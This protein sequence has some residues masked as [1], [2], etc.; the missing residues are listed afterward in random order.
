MKGAT[1]SQRDIE[2]TKLQ[3]SLSAIADDQFMV[4]N[5]P[6]G[7]GKSC[8]ADT[9]MRG[10]WGVVHVTVGSGDSL[11]DITAAT[12]RAITRS[13]MSATYDHTASAQRVLLF[14]KIFFRV[15]AAVVLQ[16]A[17][18]R[19]G[20]EYADIS[21]ACR[22]IVA[23]GNVRIIVDA[24]HNS[25]DESARRTMR[26]LVLQVEPMPREMLNALSGMEALHAALE[27]AG[28]ADVVWAVLGGYP[29]DYRGLHSSWRASGCSEA[30]APVVEQFLRAQLI[31]A[32]DTHTDA[33][34]ADKRPTP[35][36][37][38][39][40]TADAVPARE[41][42]ALEV[43]R[44]SPDK[45]LRRMERA[46]MSVLVPASPAIALVLRHD[47]SEV[48]VLDAIKAMVSSIPA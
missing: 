17:E 12:W 3:K 5:G 35:F 18:R 16:A 23:A 20:Q 31:A 25:L 43:V 47:L 45:E 39:F 6:K 9:A 15:P 2:V 34:A 26:E 4:I 37:A 41:L 36:Y 27:A 24:S 14:H 29:A 30:I 33:L 48:P 42:R 40:T 13:Q 28:L 46:G 10:G 11:K 7:V 22:H 19:S 38:R 21:A 8:L 1:V 44:P 32:I